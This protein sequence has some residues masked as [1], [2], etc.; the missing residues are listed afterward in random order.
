MTL[1]DIF[2]HLIADKEHVEHV[3]DLLDVLLA[4]PSTHTKTL[5]WARGTMAKTYTS[6]VVSPSG[7]EN[8]L[9]YIMRGVTED[10]L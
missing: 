3:Q 5:D 9:H 4:H 7:K 10:K 1:V 2:Q 6:E 8:S